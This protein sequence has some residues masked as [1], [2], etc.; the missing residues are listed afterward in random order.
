MPHEAQIG[1]QLHRSTT[2]DTCD[3]LQ[4]INQFWSQI[5]DVHSFHAA[6]C[7]VFLWRTLADASSQ[8]AAA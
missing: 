4:M 5:S 1:F 7:V 8:P 3:V 2:G 6:S